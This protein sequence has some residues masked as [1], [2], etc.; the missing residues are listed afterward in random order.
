LQCQEKQNGWNLNAIFKIRKKSVNISLRF[1]NA[2]LHR[3]EAGFLVWGIADYTHEAVGTH[4]QPREAKKGNEELGNWLLRLLQPRI[5]F[6]IHE[7][8]YTQ[9]LQEL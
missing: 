3:K 7:F 2:A 9:W 8:D 1:P 6:I 5:D 4:F